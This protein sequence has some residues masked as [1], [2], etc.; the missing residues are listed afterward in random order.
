MVD[1]MGHWKKTVLL[2]L[3]GTSGLLAQF[4]PGPLSRFHADLEGTENC[5]QCHERGKRIARERC[6]G[7]HKAL[8]A[9]IEAGEGLH[10]RPEYQTCERCHV[11]HHGRDF[12]LVYWK[13]GMEAFDHSLTGFLLEGKHQKVPCRDC[14]KPAFIRDP[15]VREAKKEA[16][17]RTFLGLSRECLSCHRDEH[18]GQ[19]QRPCLDCH[20]MEGWKPASRFDH[21]TAAFRLTGKHKD[22]PCAQCHPT[23]EDRRFPDDFEFV[24]FT[25]LAFRRCTD[26]HEDVHRGK[27][28][29]NCTKCHSTAGW[30]Q[31]KPSAFDHSLTRFPLEGKHA[32]LK[33]EA[34]HKPGRPL[35]IERFERCTDCHEDY[36]R[37]QFRN[38]PQQG[39][40]EECHTVEGW[41]PAQFTLQDHRQTDFPLEGAHI[42][43]PCR[44]CHKKEPLDG[45]ITLRFRFVS[46]RCM[47]CH[48]DPH[49]GEVDR[50]IEQGGCETCHRVESWQA[51]SFDH[52]QT[53]FPL[54]G[55]HREVA[56]TRCHVRENAGTPQEKIRFREVST[57]CADC[58]KDIHQGQ[59]ETWIADLNRR[60]TACDR[61]HTP[62][63]WNPV[64]FDHNRDSRFPLE[65][66]HR[67]VPCD[68]CHPK[69]Q[70]ISG[71]L[72][73]FKPL[74]TECRACHGGGEVK[75]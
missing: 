59:F 40:C 6:L 34:C 65:G 12:E 41:T 42:A 29:T 35:R 45:V 53:R 61:C 30:K 3:V 9:R 25:G 62:Q 32:D 16:L 27:F 66:A 33:C 69:E 43:V 73:R 4:S 74:D 36:H 10:A 13:G 20:T 21:N 46:T 63:N 60:A 67:R 18:R 15:Q 68:R 1:I 5:F 14:H 22:V 8:K 75:P 38:R 52:S 7:C 31:V 58:H 28:G 50:Y 64:K 2:L 51:V 56:C 11:E 24:R 72:V 44:T 23:V 57:F 17:D 70:G 49:K 37:G 71:E 55:K 39:A 47:D 48:P 19:F 54:E 26:C